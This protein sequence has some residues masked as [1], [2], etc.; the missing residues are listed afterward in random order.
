MMN[1]GSSGGSLNFLVGSPEATVA[2]IVAD[3][4]VKENRVLRDNADYCPACVLAFDNPYASLNEAHSATDVSSYII[5]TTDRQTE[6]RSDGWSNGRIGGQTDRTD[7]L[8][9]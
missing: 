9:L 5:E 6:R 3:V 2:D 7:G 8:T 1:V 4:I